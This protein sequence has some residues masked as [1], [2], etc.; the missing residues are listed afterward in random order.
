MVLLGREIGK[1]GVGGWQESGVGLISFQKNIVQR[2]G[3][4]VLV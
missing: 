1:E 2:G 4:N 3:V